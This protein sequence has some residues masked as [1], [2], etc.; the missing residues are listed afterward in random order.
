MLYNIKEK[1]LIRGLMAGSIFPYKQ[2]F[3][4]VRIVSVPGAF[5]AITCRNH[6]WDTPFSIDVKCVA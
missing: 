5:H 4:R 6:G 3:H 1:E 2:M